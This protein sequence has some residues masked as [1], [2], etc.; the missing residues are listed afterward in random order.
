MKHPFSI[1]LVC[2]ALLA[3]C[4]GD[5]NATDN[6]T[7]QPEVKPSPSS[8]WKQGF[9]AYYKPTSGA[10]ELS[11]ITGPYADIAVNISGKGELLFAAENSYLPVWQFSVNGQVSQQAVEQL[12]PQL[13]DKTRRFDP[14]ND[15]S[16]ARIISQNEQ[17]ILIHWRY[18]PSADVSRKND[19][20][21]FVHELF[22]ITPQGQVSR[23][24][25]PGS[26]TQTQWQALSSALEQDIKLTSNG[27]ESTPARAAQPRDSGHQ[28][29]ASPVLSQAVI[30]NPVAHWRLDEAQGQQIFD[31]QGQAHGQLDSHGEDWVSG[32]S[33]YGLRFDGYRS[34]IRVPADTL[35][36]MRA[37]TSI[38][39]WLFIGAYPWGD[40]AI[41]Q[42]KHQGGLRLSVTGSGQLSLSLGDNSVTSNK[43]LPTQEWLHIS[44]TLGEQ[45]SLYVNGEKVAAAD[46]TSALVFG[47]SD[48][49]I[50]RNAK[51]SAAIAG[52]RDAEIDKYNHFSS[53]FGIEGVLD[54][55][56]IHDTLLSA[57]QVNQRY[58]QASTAL[59]TKPLSPRA[60]P[61]LEAFPQ[62]FGAY[63]TQLS[64]HD[65][66]DNLFRVTE[67]DDIVVRFDNKP[68][69]LAYWRGT[70]HGMNL[71]TQGRWM[72]DQS[73]EMIIPDFDDAET[74]KNLKPI[75]S[76]A[77]HMSDKS[78]LR[79]HV[80]LIENSAAR[81]KVHWRYA[82]AD[83]FGTLLMD[84][85]YVDEVHTIYP[86]GVAIRSVY[87]YGAENRQEKE[88]PGVVF[89][90]DF[91][92]LLA[93]GEK[94]EDLMHQQGVSLAELN[95]SAN[96]I[97]YP[98]DY[99]PDEEGQDMPEK[100]NIAVLNSK[101]D[102]KVFGISQGNTFYPSSN[103]ERSPYVDF[104]GQAF[105]FAGPWDHW[106]V[107]Q[108]PSDGR[109]SVNKDRVSHFALGVLEAFNYGTGAM[110]YGFM[111]SQ[112]AELGDPTK[113]QD[114]GKSWVT[115]AQVAA[116]KGI[117]AGSASYDKNERAY[118]VTATDKQVEFHLNA[119][120]EQPVYHPSV[121]VHQWPSEQL[122]EVRVNNTVLVD[123]KAAIVRDRDGSPMLVVFMPIEE[124]T[125]VSVS[126]TLK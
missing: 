90:Q 75:V 44:A 64:F 15:F 89:Y 85:G 16:Y 21:A 118:H 42:Q 104:E 82:T 10:T 35:P 45:L 30:G 5:V 113:V 81:V 8:T 26:D 18:M 126:L 121:V 3:A 95:G 53:L 17:G 93:P 2:L 74:A 94:A 12:T 39:T 120:A 108:I 36:V 125:Q 62:V 71:V 24:H 25:R 33:G 41:L 52:V 100:G 67:Y 60:L 66:W 96:N 111:P 51:P 122:P 97:S 106:P 47:H 69:S 61:D 80:R 43:V 86:D 70:S 117:K 63:H 59:T 124:R 23:L 68:I 56:I 77:E 28:V 54:E 55:L 19:P 109:Y 11:N 7:K 1:S 14:K 92:W 99:V 102:W 103:A 84:E 38:E 6:N 34:Q 22:T 49:L 50:G 76:L 46:L 79:T 40:A 123:A 112:A 72:S 114:L 107:A 48:L 65:M 13:A 101:T 78:A 83:V 91:Q 119:S 87:Y 57:S 110:M 116:I 73:V 31:S 88:R 98:Y 4:G 58:Q 27:L 9:Y 20:T 115:P 32:I 29:Q 105:P 37:N